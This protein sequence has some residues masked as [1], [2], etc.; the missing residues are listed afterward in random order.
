ME[1][2][3]IHI[4]Y[5]GECDLT[6]YISD[7]SEIT[8]YERNQDYSPVI[9]TLS[10]TMKYDALPFISSSQTPAA[11]DNFYISSSAGYLF[12]GYYDAVVDDYKNREFK[13]SAKAHYGLLQDTELEYSADWHNTL[14]TTSNAWEYTAVD[15]WYAGG[16]PN[17]QVLYVLKK[18]FSNAGL[19]LDSSGVDGCELFTGG[20]IRRMAIDY[21]MLYAINQSYANKYTNWSNYVSNYISHWDFVSII[22]AVFGMIILPNGNKSY[23]LKTIGD[24]TIS[25]IGNV[26]TDSL[27]FSKVTTKTKAQYD[28][29]SYNFAW[30]NRSHY[31][32]G[33]NMNLA[34]PSTNQAGRT[35]QWF[36][37]V[38]PP[39]INTKNNA[40]V[41]WYNNLRFLL[42]SS[43][44]TGDIL[45]GN[46]IFDIQW[47]GD[48]SPLGTS[49]PLFYKHI[50]YSPIADYTNVEW[51]TQ[52]AQP[53]VYR[54]YLGDLAELT[55]YAKVDVK[56][57]TITVM[58]ERK[59]IS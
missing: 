20:T 21:N 32:L 53:F 40:I 47:V 28:S 52:I 8:V 36:T 59:T 27:T 1:F 23:K 6:N 11:Q 41:R 30:S 33:T 14:T 25:L 55:K 17:I 56:K 37:M 48:A 42:R 44:S 5:L 51:E 4:D 34:L 49:S 31:N 10:I 24:S 46:Y 57:R 45:D 18:M 39:A 7:I 22:C 19:T 15:N 2:K 12:T 26:A 35:T 3:Y 13:I 9:P 50:V 16:L 54:G 38:D 29:I 58:E 43:D